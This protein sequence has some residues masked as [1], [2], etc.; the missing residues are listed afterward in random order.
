MIY[1]NVIFNDFIEEHEDPQLT[2]IH[3]GDDTQ[4]GEFESHICEMSTHIQQKVRQRS[5]PGLLQ[6]KMQKTTGGAP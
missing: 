6:P 3:E 5:S 1:E 4:P 2:E